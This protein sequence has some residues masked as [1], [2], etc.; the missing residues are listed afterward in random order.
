MADVHRRVPGGDHYDPSRR[1]P[2]PEVD[3]SAFF[4]LDLRVGRVVEVEEFPEARDPAYK[5]TIDCGERIGRLRSS[6]KIT[7]YAPSSL[8][9]RLVVVAVNLGDKQ[10]AGFT[11]QC[12]VLG[13]LEPDGD[14]HL[15]E[16]DGGVVPGSVVS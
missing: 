7:N 8:A 3:P 14:V 5:L 13:A 6:A 9:G 2:L 16:V 11:S 10:V 12:L 15:L 4:A 1:P